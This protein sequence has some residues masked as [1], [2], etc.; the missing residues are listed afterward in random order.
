MAGIFD[1]LFVLALFVP[2]VVVLVGAL[3]LIAVPRRPVWRRVPFDRH[4]TVH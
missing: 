4:A 1:V 2:P 3:A